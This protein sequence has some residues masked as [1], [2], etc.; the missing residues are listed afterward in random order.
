MHLLTM[1]NMTRMN[2]ELVMSSLV[3]IKYFLN[4]PS[5]LQRP[6]QQKIKKSMSGKEEKSSC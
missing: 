2:A 5:S 4:N 1:M 6:Q 3:N